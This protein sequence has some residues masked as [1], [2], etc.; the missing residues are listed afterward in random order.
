MSGKTSVS[1]FFV[2]IW[3]GISKTKNYPEVTA[4]DDICIFTFD[5][6][7]TGALVPVI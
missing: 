7:L 1:F 2:F 4:A 3:G 5:T 6:N